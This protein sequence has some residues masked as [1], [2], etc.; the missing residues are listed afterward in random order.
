M[1]VDRP[2]ISDF[3]TYEHSQYPELWDGCIGAWC[4][5]LGPSGTTIPDMTIYRRDMVI[6]G[7]ATADNTWSFQRGGSSLF[8][9]PNQSHRFVASFPSVLDL[10]DSVGLS[11]WIWKEGTNGSQFAV[12]AN[13]NNVTQFIQVHTSLGIAIR[14]FAGSMGYGSTPMPSGRWVHIF[15][16]WNP[17]NYKFFFDGKLIQTVICPSR[18]Y[19]LNNISFGAILRNGS[20]DSAHGHVDD[21]RV[22]NRKLSIDEIRLLSQF[23]GI[24][25]VRR[26]RRYY[27]PL[28]D[29]SDISG[30]FSGNL[31]NITFNSQGVV[32]VSGNY[33]INP[34]GITATEQGTVLVSATYSKNFNNFNF[35]SDGSVGFPV[36]SG[37]FSGN[38]NNINFTSQGNVFIYGSQSKTL[39]NITTTEQGA[40]LISGNLNKQTDNINFS[41]SSSYPINCSLNQV[42][43][44]FELNSSVKIIVNGQAINN[45]DNISC[46]IT[47]TNGSSG[48]GSSYSG[49]I[50]CGLGSGYKK[51]K[52]ISDSSGS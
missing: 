4:P 2:T 19:Y 42:L 46:F 50:G 40:V 49:Y 22:Y 38:L 18:P 47:G 44:S 14:N 9:N 34:A 43:Q 10:Y 35:S 21:L 29:S 33:F 25:Y 17:T 30:A 48:S 16:D 1:F 36:V 8:F 41:A 28:Q 51:I 24:S 45:L 23:R 6:S 3:A 27:A 26:R 32:L 52:I 15:F 7:G 12:L 31:E 20:A 5:S 11:V 13:N 39:S 37:S